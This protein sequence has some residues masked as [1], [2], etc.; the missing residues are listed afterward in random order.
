MCLYICS[1]ACLR[2]Y[3]Y[4][5]KYVL[6]CVRRGAQLC[7]RDYVCVCVCV[8][9]RSYEGLREFVCLCFVYICKCMKVCVRVSEL[10]FESVCLSVYM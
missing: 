1:S 7:I 5:C 9:A 8:C 3:A 6:E 2:V 10:G 4:L